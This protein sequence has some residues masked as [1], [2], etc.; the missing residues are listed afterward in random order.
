MPPA[1]DQIHSSLYPPNTSYLAEQEEM[2]NKVFQL[3]DHAQ[4]PSM[5]PISS[6]TEFPV[7]VFLQILESSE[8]S[9]WRRKEGQPLGKVEQ[10]WS[11]IKAEAEKA[12]GSK[13]KQFSTAAWQKK[14]AKAKDWILC[15]TFP[16]W[17]STSCCVLRVWSFRSSTWWLALLVSWLRFLT[18]FS[19]VGSGGTGIT[20]WRFSFRSCRKVFI[21]FFQGFP[22]VSFDLKCDSEKSSS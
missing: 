7:F 6:L 8:C 3:N 15:I 14:S 21:N 17:N 19:V 1:N 13:E 10:V 18:L 4:I 22:V 9:D 5:W 16:L 20:S 11:F 2:E 12:R